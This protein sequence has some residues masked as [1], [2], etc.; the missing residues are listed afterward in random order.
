MLFGIRWAVT[1]PWVARN[2]DSTSEA[3]VLLVTGP[4]LPVFDGL[5]EWLADDGTAP[6]VPHERDRLS[7][8][9]ATR[10]RLAPRQMAAVGTP[11]NRRV[12]RTCHGFDVRERLGE[13]ACPCWPLRRTRQTDSARVSRD[14]AHEIPDG[15]VS[16]VPDAAH[17]AWSNRPRRST[18]S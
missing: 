1:C 9:P 11:V 14:T 6:S 4:E 7:T 12:F 3:I 15:E 8:T 16:F 5:Q 13:I 18:T 2:G 10:P 17:L